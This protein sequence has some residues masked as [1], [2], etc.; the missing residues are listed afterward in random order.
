M[1]VSERMLFNNLGSRMQQQ[2]FL[3]LK[4]QEQ[5]TS[6]KRINRP[7]DDPIGQAAVI[8][9][10]KSLRS[11]DQYLRNIDR[12]DAFVSVSE[13]AL[14]A[15]QDQ[16]V[17]VR[18]LAVQGANAT[19]TAADRMTIAKEIRQIYDQLISFANT[20][21]EGAY[22]F[23]GNEIKTQPL[24][25]QG[26][27]LGT[28]IS[29]SLPVTITTGSNDVLNVT[30]D[31]VTSDI[32]LAA[33][34]PTYSSSALVTALQAAFD[35][36]T[37]F[38]AAGVSVIVSYDT[39]HLVIT[40]N[41]VGGTS[42]VTLNSG[43]AQTVLGLV[44]GTGTSRPS[45]T[46]LGDSEENALLI[47]ENTSLI[48]NL[49]GDRLFKGAGGGVDIFAIVGSLQSALETNNVTGIQTALGNLTGVE[50]QVGDERGLLGARL[51]RADR[52]A[53][54]LEDFK[55]TVLRIKSET[56]DVDLARA[57]SE[58]LLQESALEATRAVSAR[59]I[60]RSLLDFLR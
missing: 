46:Y 29:G 14:R 58:L 27:H 7:S 23:A 57:I 45:G 41:A 1:R 48:K 13:D 5:I 52:T 26:R 51:N 38:Q 15:I 33:S 24:V 31:G 34:A 50:D 30:V 18:V 28:D 6:G 20:Q 53:T 44:S 32:T 16:L 22:I 60:Q 12:L 42:A 36:D 11:S 56:E 43:S 25:S 3:L 37:T 8:R 40:S 47:G 4:L 21:H 59:I 9:F 54:T 2:S 10:D 49:P 17:R 55:L 19:N 35:A 39:D